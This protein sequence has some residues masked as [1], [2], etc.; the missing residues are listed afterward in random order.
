M[1]KVI[2]Q[3]TTSTEKWTS[4]HPDSWLDL[5]SLGV[6]RQISNKSNRIRIKIFNIM[7]IINIF[8][9]LCYQ[10]NE[11]TVLPDKYKSVFFLYQ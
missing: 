2:F 11:L 3:T 8:Y 4:P 5:F 10:G 7:L 9:Y 1:V 6:F